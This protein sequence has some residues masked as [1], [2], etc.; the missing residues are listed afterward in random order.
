MGDE[1]SETWYL[2][3]SLVGESYTNED[4]TDRQAEI[5]LCR[6]G[7]NVSLRWDRANPHDP[8]AIAVHSIRGPQI[9]FLA[10]GDNVDFMSYHADGQVVGAAISAIYGGTAGKPKRG[11]SIDIEIDDDAT[12]DDHEDGD[13]DR[14]WMGI[15]GFWLLTHP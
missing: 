15:S 4:G 9:G 1:S 10:R 14:E 6:V 8:A 3:C 2:E 5:A 13:A 11:V 7:E 12:L